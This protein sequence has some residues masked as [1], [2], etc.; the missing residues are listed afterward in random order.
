MKIQWKIASTLAV[1]GALCAFFAAHSDSK[2]KRALEATRLTLRQQG[3]KI[4]LK[5]F[6]TSAPPAMRQRALM[7]FTA[8]CSPYARLIAGYGEFMPQAGSNAALVI[9]KAE[10]VK[11]NSLT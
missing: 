8:S 10:R 2:E 1:L 9:W 11:S 4:D 7:L 5:H 3:F 6:N